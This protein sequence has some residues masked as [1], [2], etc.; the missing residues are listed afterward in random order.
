[1]QKHFH[2]LLGSNIVK[3]KK[4]LWRDMGKKLKLW[5]H[6]LKKPLTIR[7]DDTPNSVKVRAGV[8]I[9]K[10]DPVDVDILLAKWCKKKN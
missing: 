1:M 5:R 2:I 7:A 9:L 8:T 4:D 3:I 6:K 10:Y